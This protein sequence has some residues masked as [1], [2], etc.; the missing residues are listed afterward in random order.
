VGL[1]GVVLM[2]LVPNH[3]SDVH[4]WFRRACTDR[5]SP[6]RH[7]YIWRDPGPAGGAPNNGSGADMPGQKFAG[8]HSTDSQTC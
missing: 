1:A 5:H 3:T 2:D 8:Q 4:E 6:Y 7:F